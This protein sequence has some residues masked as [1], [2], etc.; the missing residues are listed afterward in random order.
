MDEHLRVP[1]AV[2]LNSS[3]NEVYVYVYVALYV[4]GCHP[5]VCSNAK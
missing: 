2:V 3:V 4:S 1:D 5:R